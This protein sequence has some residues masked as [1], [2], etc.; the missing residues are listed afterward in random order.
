MRK[1]VF[2]NDDV[3]MEIEVYDKSVFVHYTV[4]KWNKS[5]YRY[6]MTLLSELMDNLSQK[7]VKDIYAAVR[8]E[9]TKLMKFCYLFGFLPLVLCEDS[10]TYLMNLEI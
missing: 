10:N 8:K 4:T 7:G 2:K 5:I 1:Q 9:D 6:S 3:C